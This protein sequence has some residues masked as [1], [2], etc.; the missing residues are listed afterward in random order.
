[1]PVES[2][3]AN[4]FVTTTM[5]NFRGRSLLS[6]YAIEETGSLRSAAISMGL[7][8]TKSAP[9]NLKMP[10]RSA[11]TDPRCVGGKSGGWKYTT[12]QG[13]GMADKI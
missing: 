6:A 11:S 13:K 8:Y 2:G 12:P 7:A 3:Y 1:M 5:K 4:Y 10:S 9:H